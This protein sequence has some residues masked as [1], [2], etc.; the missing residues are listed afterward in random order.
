MND[1]DLYG[2][3]VDLGAARRDPNLSI[4]RESPPRPPNPLK[5]TRRETTPIPSGL[6]SHALFAIACVLAIAGALFLL[7]ILLHLA[8]D[9]I[10]AGW[11]ILWR[12]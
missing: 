11:T 9:A 4:R 7:G 5:P 12:S 8:W 6:I 3:T 2:P 10:M 1:D